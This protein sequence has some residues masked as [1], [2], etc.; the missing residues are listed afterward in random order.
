MSTD[1]TMQD[2]GS[3]GPK[4][5]L[6]P[7]QQIGGVTAPNPVL[8]QQC[9]KC[10]KPSVPARPVEFTEEFE[11]TVDETVDGKT[12][13]KKVKGTRPARR[14]EVYGFC[15]EHGGAAEAPHKKTAEEWATLRGHLPEFFPGEKPKGPDGKPNKDAIVPPVWNPNYRFYSEPRFLLWGGVIGKELTLVEYDAGTAEA[16]NHV[17][18]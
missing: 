7:T 14:P 8:V 1:E 6:A 13:Q 5:P 3:E 10:E 4:A 2:E 11:T 15:A 12:T 9:E 16:L 17:F 18:R